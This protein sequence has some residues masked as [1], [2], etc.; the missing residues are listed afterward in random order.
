VSWRE[1]LKKDIT[2]KPFRGK[3]PAR[4]RKIFDMDLTPPFLRWP[5]GTGL[6]GALMHPFAWFAQQWHAD[7]RSVLT[8]L[9][10]IVQT[11]SPLPDGL[12]VCSLDA[13]NRRV[14]RVLER[15]SIRLESGDSLGESMETLPSIFPQHWV[16]LIHAG[17]QTGRLALALKTLILETNRG[18][19]RGRVI[20]NRITY[21]GCLLLA[22]LGIMSFIS[23]K[24]IPVFVEV[25]EEFGELPPRSAT[26]IL[27]VIQFLEQYSQTLGWGFAALFLASILVPILHRRAGWVQSIWTYCLLPLPGLGRLHR[28]KNLERIAGV[29][30]MLLTGGVP[31]PEALG[32]AAK[33]H[34]NRPFQKVMASAQRAVEG[35]YPLSEAL[36]RHRY[37]MGETLVT[38]VK[39]GEHSG[40]LDES[41]GH[42]REFYR[43]AIT[44]TQSTLADLLVPSGVF[45]CGSIALLTWLATFGSFIAIGD[46]IVMAM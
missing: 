29:L 26:I 1:F 18:L 6:L 45:V 38:M 2:P 13:P 31:L 34:V 43:R 20:K 3:E 41:C 21:F 10:A 46:A 12:A 22:Q 39:L 36:S 42:A 25:V 19:E 27:Q 14:A 9:E 32:V 33:A 11:N 44:R 30:Q 28:N 7:L 15:L 35:G 17:E 5:R 4:W 40:G 8:Q 37:L 24:V 16:D 23:I